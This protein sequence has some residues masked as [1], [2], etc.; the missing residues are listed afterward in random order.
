[1]L[2]TVAVTPGSAT[3]PASAAIGTPAT[4]PATDTPDVEPET[5]AVAFALAEP[6]STLTVA[7]VPFTP[8]VTAGVTRSPG[9]G[10]P[11]GPAPPPGPESPLPRG[12]GAA[13]GEPAAGGDATATPGAGPC[14]T[15]RALTLTAREPRLPV[16]RCDSSE[17][18]LTPPR[19]AA[20]SLFAVTTTPVLCITPAGV[21][22]RLS[23]T[24]GWRCGLPSASRGISDSTPRSSNDGNENTPLSSI[25]SGTSAVA[26]AASAAASRP[27]TES[28]LK[29][30]VA[31]PDTE[32]AS[33]LRFTGKPFFEFDLARAR[34]TLSPL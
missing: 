17:A 32:T 9:P 20:R 16:T 10:P 23:A 13:R 21:P 4:A 28:L 27:E 7:V 14:G 33:S 6:V 15:S 1:M 25:S 31:P 19:L 12:P 22:K 34:R 3:W 11:P 24:A 26:T 2:P 8:T 29:A 5:V 18:T 30:R